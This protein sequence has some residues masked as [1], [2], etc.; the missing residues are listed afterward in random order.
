MTSMLLERMSDFHDV[1]RVLATVGLG[2]EKVVEIHAD[3]A[4][5]FRVERV[6]DV[7]EGGE[8]ALEETWTSAMTLQGGRRILPEDSGP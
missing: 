3:G 4:G 2:D 6:L 8:A 1:E 5:E 7:D